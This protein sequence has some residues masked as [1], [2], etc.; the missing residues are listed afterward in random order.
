MPHP[1][2]LISGANDKYVP[3]LLET[4]TSLG[5]SI[6]NYDIGIFDLGLSDESIS[7]LSSLSSHVKIVKLNWLRPIPDQDKQPSYKKIFLAKA[8]IPDFFPG[9]DGYV[10]IDADIWFPDP[11]AI[12][13]YIEASA[14]TGIAVSYE[15]HPSY[16]TLQ[17]YRT[18]TLLGKTFIKGVKS[19]KF[20]KIKDYFGMKL[21]V[22]WGLTPIMNSGIFCIRAN[23]QVWK[24]W[25]EKIMTANLSKSGK[26][27]QICDQTCLD[28]A[29]HEGG[30][31]HTIMPATH[32]WCVELARPLICR[33]SKKLLD[34]MYP[35]APIKVV[36]LL[37][38]S[39][40]ETYQVTKTDGKTVTT[41]LTAAAI[42]N[43][44]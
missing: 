28:L 18:H 24:A 34:P 39:M 22:K 21:A 6:E 27:T 36:H 20:R 33:N 23:S 16:K 30:L 15:C 10:W 3:F 9:Y 32:N 14:V 12:D 44:A 19:Y 25:Q 43:L 8:F 26:S 41:K 42:Q 7:R 29:V 17:K 11:T 37:G 2:I 4:L 40:T 31:T 5:A 13:D 1:F 38:D 35:H